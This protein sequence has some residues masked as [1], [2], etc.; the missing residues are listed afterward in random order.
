MHGV[1]D[2]S[3]VLNWEPIVSIGVRTW[4]PTS[5][6]SGAGLTSDAQHRGKRSRGAHSSAAHREPA[7]VGEPLFANNVH[8]WSFGSAR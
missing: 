8:A 7:G 5:D 6:Y 4:R 1:V 2:A 3:K